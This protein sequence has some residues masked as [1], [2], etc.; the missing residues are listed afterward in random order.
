MLKV[1]KAANKILRASTPLD[2]DAFSQGQ[3]FNVMFKFWWSI[4]LVLTAVPLVAALMASS[5]GG[6]K[7]LGALINWRLSR[8]LKLKQMRFG[9]AVGVGVLAGGIFRKNR[10]QTWS[11]RETSLLRISRQPE[12]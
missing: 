9:V 5:K 3:P 11:E 8:L 7:C 12:T 6:H 4:Y 1:L 10:V 2:N